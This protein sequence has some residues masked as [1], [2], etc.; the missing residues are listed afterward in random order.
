MI[1]QF[2]E[3]GKGN[4]FIALAK[5]GETGKITLKAKKW[6]HQTVLFRLNSSTWHQKGMA[7]NL[8]TEMIFEF[9]ELGTLLWDPTVPEAGSELTDLDRMLPPSRATAGGRYRRVPPG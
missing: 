3:L 7:G 1:E 4:L 8:Q 9:G 6:E 5:T 2:L